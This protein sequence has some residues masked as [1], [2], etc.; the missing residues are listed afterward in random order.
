MS[1][2]ETLAN[3]YVLLTPGPLTTTRTVKEVML[4]DWCTWDNDYNDIVQEIRQ[5]ARA[6]GRGSPPGLLYRAC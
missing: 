4:R 5:H 2:P 3:P 6:D 1:V